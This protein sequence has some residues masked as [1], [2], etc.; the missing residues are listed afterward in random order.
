[1]ILSSTILHE[2]LQETSSP[3][4]LNHPFQLRVYVIFAAISS[5][6]SHSPLS[7]TFQ[8]SYQMN[9]WV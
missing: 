3:A 1:M 6:D 9:A 5:L 7:Y 4:T 8:D 2:V